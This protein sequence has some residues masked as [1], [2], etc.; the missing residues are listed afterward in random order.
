M[1]LKIIY[2]RE[3]GTGTLFAYWGGKVAGL[4]YREKARVQKVGAACTRPDSRDP[5]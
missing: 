4:V 2:Y 3:K 1:F 5:L